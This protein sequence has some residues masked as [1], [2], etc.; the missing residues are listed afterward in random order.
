MVPDEDDAGHAMVAES[1]VSLDAVTTAV[2]DVLAT[3]MVSEV[4]MLPQ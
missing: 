2:P 4:V 3:V 1:V